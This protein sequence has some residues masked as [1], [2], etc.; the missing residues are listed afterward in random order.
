[1]AQNN[2]YFVS[3]IEDK[4][5]FTLVDIGA[6]GGVPEKWRGM[7]D[8]MRIIAFEPDPREFPKL[9]SSQNIEYLNCALH[10]KSEDLK[11]YVANGPGKSSIF[12]PNIGILSQFEDSDRFKIIR[13]EVI[14][15]A[16]VKTLDAVI[17]ENALSDVDF[18]KIDT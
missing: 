9:K 18:I 8:V 6:M 7:F 13:E 16:R 15:A 1:M 2:D 10:D 17:E 12:R 4:Y 11:Y 5:P 14:P 3:K